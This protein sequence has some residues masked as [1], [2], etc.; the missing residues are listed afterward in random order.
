MNVHLD[1]KQVP[2]QDLLPS[3]PLNVEVLQSVFYPILLRLFSIL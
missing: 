2:L 3:D 1:L